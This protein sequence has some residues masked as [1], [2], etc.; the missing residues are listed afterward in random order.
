MPTRDDIGERRNKFERRVLQRAGVGSEDEADKEED[1]DADANVG[2]SSQE[3]TEADESSED[4]FYQQVKRERETKLA[5]KADKF[6]RFVFLLEPCSSY[7]LESGINSD[8]KLCIGW[9]NHYRTT[10]DE[11]SFP[12]TVDGKRHIS[13]QVKKTATYEP[14]L[15]IHM[16]KM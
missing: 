11:P 7:A 15:Y 3:G 2:S 6:S 5:S 16:I 8:I 9:L 1:D 13:Y 10:T 14:A 4:E 12:E